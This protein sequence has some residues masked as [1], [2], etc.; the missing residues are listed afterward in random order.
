MLFQTILTFVDVEQLEVVTEIRVYHADGEYEIHYGNA[1]DYVV[2]DAE[3]GEIWGIYDEE[4]LY[5]MFEPVDECDC[6]DCQC[7]AEE[8]LCDEPAC[9]CGCCAPEQPEQPES[10]EPLLGKSLPPEFEELKNRQ[11][12]YQSDVKLADGFKP[13]V[14]YFTLPLKP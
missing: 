13:Q 12:Q 7:C 14:Y 10:L 8:A 3:T 1:G 2:S 6:E 11:S 9:D 4:E 5:D